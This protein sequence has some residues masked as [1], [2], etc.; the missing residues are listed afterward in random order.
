VVLLN[1]I[2]N[3]LRQFLLAGEIGSVSGEAA[4]AVD[5]YI[6]S[7]KEVEAGQGMYG[8]YSLKT[9]ARNNQNGLFNFDIELSPLED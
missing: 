3:C 2:D 5:S 4:T 6:D 8:G 1:E 9:L 7:L